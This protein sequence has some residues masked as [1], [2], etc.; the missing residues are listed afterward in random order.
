MISFIMLSGFMIAN[1]LYDHLVWS[2][3]F[4]SAGYGPIDT[5]K[6]Y[7]QTQL[8]I[9]GS[10]YNGEIQHYTKRIDNAIVHSGHL[11]LIAK[12]ETLTD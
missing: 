7:H 1:P 5:S 8:P 2:D 9:G 6:W 3:E 10:W 12:K 4:N 11:H